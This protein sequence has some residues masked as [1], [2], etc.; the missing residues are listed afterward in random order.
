MALT[1]IQI[2]S[3]MVEMA[4]MDLWIYSN[5]GYG[6]LRGADQFGGFLSAKHIQ[7][8]CV[9]RRPSGVIELFYVY[10]EDS[11]EQLSP[12]DALFLC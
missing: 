12:G 2:V 9:Y 3:S 11:L 10:F 5:P 4:A 6:E 1:V 8:D 7:Q